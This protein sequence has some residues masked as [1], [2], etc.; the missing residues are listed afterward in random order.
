MCIKVKE[1]QCIGCG[2]CIAIDPEHFD[3]NPE[4]GTS[5]VISTE[6]TD[7]ESVKEAIDACPVGAIS[8]E[9]KTEE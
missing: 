3:F 4:N 5:T 9:E 1:D 7:S 8:K 6:N 2:A